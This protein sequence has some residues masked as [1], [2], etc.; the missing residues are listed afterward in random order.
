M[1]QMAEIIKLGNAIE[2]KNVKGILEVFQDKNFHINSYG[3]CEISPLAS[4]IQDG[5]PEL[6]E[7]FLRM[8]ANVHWRVL[9]GTESMLYLAITNEND[10][11]ENI[12]KKVKV[13]LAYGAREQPE[14]QHSFVQLEL[15]AAVE[16]RNKSA[17]ELLLTYGFNPQRPIHRS[18]KTEPLE[19]DEPNTAIEIAKDIGYDDLA[20][21]M[22]SFTLDNIKPL[23]DAKTISLKKS[24]PFSL[25]LKAT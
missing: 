15:T 10:T 17:L 18:T 4:A 13:L 3:R 9:N 12:I 5:T 11:K 8:G 24:L 2:E 21:F 19:E 23:L 20:E 6:V 25:V 22:G 16:K 14:T 7:L 1:T